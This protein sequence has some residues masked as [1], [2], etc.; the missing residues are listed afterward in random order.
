LVVASTAA[1]QSDPLPSWNDGDAKKAILDFVAHTTAAGGADFVAAPECIAVFDN[2][3]TLWTEQP[4]EREF[5]YD[6][7]S[8]I[9]TGSTRRSTRRRVANGPSST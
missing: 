3:S 6:R 7:Q 2:D 9:S 4:I 5:A 8:H 1:A